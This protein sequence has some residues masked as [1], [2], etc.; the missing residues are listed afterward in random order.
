[1]KIAAGEE[2]DTRREERNFVEQIPVKLRVVPKFSSVK[3]IRAS[4]ARE[5]A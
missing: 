3:D 1:M 2:D 5:R 4:E